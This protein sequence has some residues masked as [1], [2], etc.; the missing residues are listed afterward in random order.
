LGQGPEYLIYFEND[1]APDKSRMPNDRFSAERPEGS[2]SMLNIQL[3]EQ[4][5]SA[6]YL[7]ASSLATV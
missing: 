7:C 6:T 4:G 2:S 1:V 5:D 3:V